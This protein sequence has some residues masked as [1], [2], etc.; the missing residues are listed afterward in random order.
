MPDNFSPPQN[1][2]VIL[3]VGRGNCWTDSSRPLTSFHYTGR[4]FWFPEGTPESIAKGKD[5]SVVVDEVSVMDRMVLGSHDGVDVP[6]Q[7]I[8]DV[9]SP[10]GRKEKKD[11][12]GQEVA[13][14]ERHHPCVR[15]GLQDTVEWVEGQ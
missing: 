1:C 7:S 10:Q 2:S 5:L 9:G 14:D 13:R 4:P 6:I 3:F 8:V 12:M 11:E 15:R